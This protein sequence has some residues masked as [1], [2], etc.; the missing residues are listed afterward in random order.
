MIKNFQ[1]DIL[2]TL[3]PE[4]KNDQELEKKNPL[5]KLLKKKKFKFRI[6]NRKN[7]IPKDSKYY[8]F[9]SKEYQ[10]IKRDRPLLSDYYKKYAKYILKKFIK[11]EDLVVEIA[12]NDGI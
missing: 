2:T 5:L 10:K 3:I 11:K 6:F 8:E 9:L 4:V 1:I 7:E 12:S